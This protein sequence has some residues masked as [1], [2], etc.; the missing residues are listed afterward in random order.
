MS[1]L[2]EELLTA[3]ASPLLLWVLLGA[4]GL[5]L[6]A[7]VVGLFLVVRGYALLAYGVGHL[8]LVGVGLAVLLDGP[9]W[10]AALGAALLGAWGL[11]A[12]RARQVGGDAA[13]AFLLTL[14]LGG[15]LLLAR[16]GGIPTGRLEAELFG[17]LA[18]L[19]PQ[20][21][22]WIGGLSLGALAALLGLY[23]PLM[24]AWVDEEAAQV[25]GLPVR[26][27]TAGL[28]GLAALLVVAAGRL[29]G[30]LLAVAQVLLPALAALPLARSFAQ[31]VGFALLFGVVMVDA[32]ILLAYFADWVPSGAIVLV[33]GG[34]VGLA[35][36]G[37]WLRSRLG[38]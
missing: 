17:H 33:G 37:G 36:L 5:A 18:V 13:V 25:E 31:A 38:S 9:R 26:G 29:T 22:V 23:R 4:T 1:G 34:L 21:L 16:L 24:A 10:L 15:G 30:L 11:E 12:L 2:L 20:D 3:F 8:A 7:A 28:V 19:R 32:G 6:P 14:G 27:V 35:H